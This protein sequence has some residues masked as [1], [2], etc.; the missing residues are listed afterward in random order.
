MRDMFTCQR[1]GVMLT[2]GRTRPTDAVVHHKTPHKGDVDL[3]YAPGNVEA[4]CK[5]YHD[6]QLQQEEALGYNP[7]IGADGW[8]I[9]PDNP[10]SK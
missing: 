2:Q 9:D 7:E 4:V 8:P 5:E 10:A 1:T 6:K 3:F